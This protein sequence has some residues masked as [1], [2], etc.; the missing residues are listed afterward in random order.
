MTAEMP[1]LPSNRKVAI[2]GGAKSRTQAPYDDD[3]WDIWAFSSLRL[4][5]PRI[6]CWFEMHSCEDLQDR[7][8]RD[9]SRR[10]SYRSYMQFLQQLACPIYMQRTHEI[11][12]NSIEYP[13]QAALD[14]FGRCFTSTASY[15][16]ALAILKGYETIG[17]WGIH[18][19]EKTV[20]ARQRPGVE[21]LLGVARQKG[22]NVYLPKNSPLR[23][24]AQPILTPTDVLYGYDWD[25]PQAWWRKVRRKRMRRHQG[26]R[27]AT[28]KG[29]EQDGRR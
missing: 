17:V 13:L 28:V 7:L 2:I 18:L 16:I 24:P 19:T 27:A 15:L 10:Y 6:T 1:A 12:P 5:T 29:C 22:I 26:C 11:L 9:T 14:A 21:Y 20:Y 25:S 23:I 8:R 4:P 3:T